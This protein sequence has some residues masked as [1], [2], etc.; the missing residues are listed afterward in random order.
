MPSQI[1]TVLISTLPHYGKSSRANTYIYVIP[2]RNI[3]IALNFNRYIIAALSR[4]LPFYFF[5]KTITS[6][7]WWW[8]KIGYQSNL[9]DCL[10]WPVPC[11]RCQLILKTLTVECTRYTPVEIISGFFEG[12]T[13]SSNNGS[14][15][16]QDKINQASFPPPNQATTLQYTQTSN[17]LIRIFWMSLWS[18][19]FQ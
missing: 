14:W 9:C 5:L 1:L 17:G 2:F 7:L 11:T 15:N 4:L 13:I 8:N 18:L 16:I 6:W 10:K 12:M 19:C 3:A